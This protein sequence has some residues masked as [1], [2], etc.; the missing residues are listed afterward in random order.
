MANRERIKDV[1]NFIEGMADNEKLA[2]DMGSWWSYIVRDPKRGPRVT[3]FDIPAYLRLQGYTTEDVCGT[4]MCFAG[5]ALYHRDLSAPTKLLTYH[6]ASEAADYLELTG[7]Q[8]MDIFGSTHVYTVDELRKVISE[9][10]Y[11]TE[12]AGL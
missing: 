8:A 1:L 4:S 9:V 5:W 11:E 12:G 10:L 7:E 2:F 3:G 6:I